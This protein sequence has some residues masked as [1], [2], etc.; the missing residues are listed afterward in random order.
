MTIPA[1]PPPTHSGAAARLRAA[2]ISPAGPMPGFALVSAGTLVLVVMATLAKYLGARI[3]AFELLLFRAGAGL[4]FVLPALRGNF[5]EPF[6]TKR[7]GMHFFRGAAGAAGNLCFFWTLTHMLLA[8]S[9]AL[10][11]SRPLWTIPLALFFL[12]E[13]AGLR[14]GLITIAGFAGIMLY[15]RPFTSGFDANAIVGGFGGFFGAL[16][17]I[18][19][20]QLSKTE[21]TRVIMF[22]YAVWNGVFALVPA[23]FVWVTPL[24]WEWPL[25]VLIGFLGIAGQS[26]V[27][28]GI[29][30]GDATALAPLDYSRI[31]YAAAI[32]YAVFG[33][34]PG[35]WSLLGM[36]LVVL[37]SVYLVLTEKRAAR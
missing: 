3:P 19:I 14:R 4:L 6:Q 7:F 35:V 18:G 11:F 20:K 2:F 29:A 36:A 33:E 17:I 5:W 25:L 24:G 37:T 12:G 26:L 27:T 23:I 8:D 16:V 32:G 31:V 10:Q 22:Y 9:M 30:L 15:A 28:K 34:I 1:A 21:S 13:W